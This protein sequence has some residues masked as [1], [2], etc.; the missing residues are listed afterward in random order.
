MKKFLW[1][2][3]ATMAMSLVSAAATITQNCGTANSAIGGTGSD[4]VTCSSPAF[5]VG[6][7]F[8]ITLVE[9]IITTSYNQNVNSANNGPDGD[10]TINALYNPTIGVPDT[11][12]CNI[13]RSGIAADTQFCG[14]VFTATP[15]ALA[16]SFGPFNVAVTF[17][18]VVDTGNLTYEGQAAGGVSVR[19][20][21]DLI[22]T[23]QVPEPTA[24]V[25]IGAGLVGLATAIR[26]RRRQ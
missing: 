1:L 8:Q 5:T 16:N 25:L 26:R 22:P 10:L 6:S 2:A 19:Y 13:A 17:T 7:S 23:G 11:A 24:T 9:L 18:K 12:P 15:A 3:L 4:S 20:T 14:V 21:Y